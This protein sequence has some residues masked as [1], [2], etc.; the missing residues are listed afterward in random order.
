MSLYSTRSLPVL[1][2]DQSAGAQI[3]PSRQHRNRRPE[4]RRPLAESLEIVNPQAD[5]KHDKR[6]YDTGFVS[7][8]KYRRHFLT[9]PAPC[10]ELGS[11][12]ALDVDYIVE[13]SVRREGERF[14]ISAQLVRVENQVCLWAQTYDRAFDDILT[15][16][17]QVAQAIAQE[18][19]IRL[20][21]D[22]KLG[23]A[24]DMP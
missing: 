3:S 10:A 12:L 22:N 9:S 24:V 23:Q 2:E 17:V 20:A 18:I 14:R 4:G 5:E 6:F 11:E 7:I 13:G 8:R 1:A 15:L 21:P 19:G 16:E